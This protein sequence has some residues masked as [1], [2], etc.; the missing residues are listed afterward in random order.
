MTTGIRDAIDL[1]ERA[2]G[3][4]KAAEAA[5]QRALAEL[6]QAQGHAEQHRVVVVEL[7]ET[8]FA[9]AEALNDGRYQIVTGPFGMEARAGSLL[10]IQRHDR[11][12]YHDAG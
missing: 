6:R 2:M 11:P 8:E 9:I 12:D 10:L 3:D 5:A 7:S 1:L 4:L